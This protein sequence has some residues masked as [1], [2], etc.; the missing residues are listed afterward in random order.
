MGNRMTS[1]LPVSNS[2]SVLIFEFT[3]T[4]LGAANVYFM[5]CLSIYVIFFLL[6]HLL[7]SNLAC[8]GGGEV[9][10]IL[11]TNDAV[12]GWGSCRKCPSTDIPL[13]Q[14]TVEH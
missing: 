11:G 8:L 3:M 4:A 10:A 12:L 1:A 7:G 13:K 14:V 9:G 5:L 6:K 2:I